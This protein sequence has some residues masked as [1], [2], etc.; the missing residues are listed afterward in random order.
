M[1][2]ALPTHKL[3]DVPSLSIYIPSYDAEYGATVVELKYPI[4][5]SEFA[6]GAPRT[7]VIKIL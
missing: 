7:N 5:A 1:I 6:T 2:P 4:L 3:T